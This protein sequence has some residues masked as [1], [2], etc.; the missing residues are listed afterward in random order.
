[1][2]ERLDHVSI[3]VDD[4]EKMISFYG[5]LLGI[6]V[7]RRA[8]IK[9]EWIEDL[10]GLEEMEA[11]VAYFELPEGPGVE[12]IQY[13]KPE[14]FRPEN[15]G[16]PNTRGIRHIALCVKNYRQDDRGAQGSRR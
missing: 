10:T 8:V 7:S 16:G 2:I 4:I 5:G 3:N 1:M 15:L 14:G 9:G 6:S 12:L 13:R 11:E